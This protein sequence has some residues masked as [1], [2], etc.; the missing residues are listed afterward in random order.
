MEIEDGLQCLSLES[1]Y[2]CNLCAKL[3]LDFIPEFYY[4]FLIKNDEAGVIK[5]SINISL[6]LH[7]S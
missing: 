4:I 7:L 1:V 5:S 3:R 2:F 6:V